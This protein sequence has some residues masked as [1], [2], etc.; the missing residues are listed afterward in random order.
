MAATGNRMRIR[1]D[2]INKVP[3][4]QIERF[5]LLQM[6]DVA[7]PVVI[8]VMEFGEGVVVRRSHDPNIINADFF[9][10]LQIVV[11]DHALR[12]NDGHFTDFSWLKPAALNGCEPFVWEE[13]RHVCHVLN[14]WTDVRV[15]LTVNR[16]WEFTENVQY[17]GNIVRRQIP[18]DI[19]VLL[20]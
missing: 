2:T 9:A 19:D 4:G 16:N 17:N 8:R 10:R 13:Q 20:E 6:R 15:S 5:F 14:P 3:T 1:L 7:I 12:P 18:S 11:H